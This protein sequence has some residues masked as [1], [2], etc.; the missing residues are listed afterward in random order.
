MIPA[1]LK[2]R[3]FLKTFILLMVCSVVGGVVGGGMMGA[4]LGVACAAFGCSAA[5][6]QTMSVVLGAGAGFVI[7]YFF[8]RWFVIRFIVSKL[9]PVVGIITNEKGPV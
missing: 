5:T 1:P 9:S 7:S 6:M 4:I 8:F 3:D 2:E